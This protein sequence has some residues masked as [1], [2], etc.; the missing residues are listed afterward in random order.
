MVPEA[1]WPMIIGG[2]RRPV[3]PS[4][5]C[6]SLPQIPHAFTATSTSC[7]CTSGSGTS[8]K[9]NFLY[10]F[11][12]SAFMVALNQAWM[13]GNGQREIGRDADLSVRDHKGRDIALRC[14][15]ADSAKP[16]ESAWH[17]V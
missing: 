7:G 9:L 4:I 2:R 12:T 16:N 5:P 14:P 8:S 13:Q 11:R 6:T 10:S 17:R 1:S 3:L 15:G